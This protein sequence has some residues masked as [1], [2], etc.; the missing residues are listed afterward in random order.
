MSVS[1]NSICKQFS[2]DSINIHIGGEIN[3]LFNDA[4][5]LASNQHTFVK[6]TIYVGKTSTFQELINNF[7]ENTFVLT[8]DNG[9]Y[10]KDFTSNGLNIIELKSTEDIFEIFNMT[11]DLFI[12]DTI[13]KQ[14]TSLLLKSGLSGKGID[15]IIQVAASILNNPLIF[16]DSNYKILAHSDIKYITD[17]LWLENLKNNHCTYDFIAGVKKLKSVQKSIKEDN[18]FEVKCTDNPTLKLVSRVVTDGKHI[19]SIIL[20]VSRKAYTLEDKELLSL[21]STIIGEE[22]KKN[23]FHR[24][25]D[26]L[27]FSELIYDVLESKIISSKV[28]NEYIKSS[29]IILSKRFATLAID[30]S[31]YKSAKKYTS[32]LTDNLSLYFSTSNT[33]YYK[34][35]IIIICDYDKFNV[36]SKVFEDFKNFLKN[37][38]L[39]A[40][41]SKD[42]SDILYFKKYYQQSIR[43]LEIG[44]IID[45]ENPYT[46]YSDIQFY[47][48]VSLTC[49]KIDYLEFYHPALIKLRQYDREN[50]SDLFNTLYIYLKNNQHLLK[51]ASELFIHRN[52]MSYRIKK[53][54]NLVNIDLSCSE[55][56]FNLMLSYKLM[57]YPKLFNNNE[58]EIK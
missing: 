27:A 33:V 22:M 18:V 51:T 24:N 31:K 53:I 9:M 44:K 16:I 21:T 19:G 43:A 48:L 57:A 49:K 47:D 8:N 11:S 39:K 7:K 41:L 13:E 58:S 25:T 32:Y 38:G 50:N 36:K 2:E 1:F 17:P 30:I 29:D 15:G 52:T 34:D 46:F 35:N 6:D 37:N 42:F 3:T 56:V 26:N 20:L 23:N 55:T 4:K 40:G 28:L 10:C 14:N 45:P 12:E 54:F 5:L